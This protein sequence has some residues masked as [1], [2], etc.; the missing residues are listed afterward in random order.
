MHQYTE[1]DLLAALRDVGNGKSLRLASREWGVPLTTLHDRNK[2]AENRT[3]GA[4]SL[5]RLSKTQE[6]HLST[7]VL[8][9]EALGV[10]LTYSQ[11][12]QFVSRLLAIKGDYQQLGKRWMEGFL[13]RNPILRTKRARNI[14]SVRVN[15]ATT[16]IIKSWFQRLVLPTIA[17]IKP[18]NRWNMDESGIMEGCGANG[19]VVGS[20]A[21][22]SIQKKQP[23]SRAWTSFIECVSAAGRALPPLVIFKGKSVQQQWFPQ[24]LSPYEGWEFTATDNVWTSDSTAV[25]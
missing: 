21:R 19:L 7:W 8:A 3:L 25:E 2:G 23:G 10:P 18:E 1:Q 6:E 24:D 13:R 9:Q 17:T 11:I 5:Q 22:R 12:R 14:D 16:A 20:S 15:G 4:E